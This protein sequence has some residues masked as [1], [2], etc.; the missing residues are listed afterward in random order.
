[1]NT[2][3]PDVAAIADEADTP[4]TRLWIIAAGGDVYVLHSQFVADLQ[5]HVCVV[6]YLDA[7]M[8]RIT[9]ERWAQALAELEKGD[10][11]LTIIDTEHDG[12]RTVGGRSRAQG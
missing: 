4:D 10:D 5:Y 6:V 3:S 9:P 7:R 11:E 1:M 8:W 2:D 12:P